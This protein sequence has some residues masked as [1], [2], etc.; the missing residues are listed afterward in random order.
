VDKG[1]RRLIDVIATSRLC[2][3]EPV[4]EG[5]RTII[6]VARVRVSG[7]W[8]TG[9]FAGRRSKGNG[10]EGGDQGE[11]GAGAGGGGGGYIEGQPIGFIEVSAEGSRFHE[12]PDPERTQKLLRNGA[13]AVGAVL[14]AI[15][16]A[17][18]ISRVAE[19]RPTGLLGRGR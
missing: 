18:G 6:P 5:E 7:G 9:R 8:G 17:R 3:G 10:E 16:G 14:T 12:I 15:A 2:Y 4:R 11:Q 13:K 19:R 1:L